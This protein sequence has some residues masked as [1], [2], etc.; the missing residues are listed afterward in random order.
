MA[1]ACSHARRA[2]L[3]VARLV[4]R[5]HVGVGHK[6]GVRLYGATV[7]Q[8]IKACA[9]HD[10]A[11]RCRHVAA[12]P[13]EH[14]GVIASYHRKVVVGKIILQHDVAQRVCERSRSLVMRCIMVYVR[15]RRT[16]KVHARYNRPAARH[17]VII[18]IGGIGSNVSGSIDLG[19]SQR[20]KRKS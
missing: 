9:Q 15:C 1:I 6:G 17:V 18:I 8:R 16:R 11:Q 19:S 3:H 20:A 5:P 2:G 10:V 7:R 13:L 14:L 12:E 4:L